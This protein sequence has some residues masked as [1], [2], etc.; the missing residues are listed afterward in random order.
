[1]VGVW[2]KRLLCCRG[3][4]L[5]IGGAAVSATG[6]SMAEGWEED[7]GGEEMHRNMWGTQ[8]RDRA[9][10]LSAAVWLGTFDT[11]HSNMRI[12][13]ATACATRAF[14]SC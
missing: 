6:E 1:M 10:Y 13:G 5:G 12:V 11:L 7:E 4:I 3:G 2:V 14:A 9:A 8:R